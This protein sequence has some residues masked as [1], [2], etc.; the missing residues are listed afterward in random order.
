MKTSQ[1]RC[2]LE[3]NVCS[4]DVVEVREEAFTAYFYLNE[5]IGEDDER[6]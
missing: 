5:I 3:L 1:L 2:G 6:I 4:G